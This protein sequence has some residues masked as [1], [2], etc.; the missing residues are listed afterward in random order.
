MEVKRTHMAN[1]PTVSALAGGFC[2]NAWR[3]HKQF[4]TF[5]CDLLVL[6]I[7]TAFLVPFKLGNLG[8]QA[9][10]LEFQRTVAKNVKEAHSLA[11][12]S[13]ILVSPV[14]ANAEADKSMALRC[15]FFLR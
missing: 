12:F 7:N 8:L 15:S 10:R 5:L 2:L 3:S 1:I 6:A 11:R 14:G 13:S 4:T 9:K